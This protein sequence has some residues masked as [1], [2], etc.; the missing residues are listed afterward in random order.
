MDLIEL[1]DLEAARRFVTE[2]LWLQRAVKPNADT[3]L[4]V[5]GS[6][7]QVFS[8]LD[9]RLTLLMHSSATSNACVPLRPMP[10]ARTAS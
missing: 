4:A 7:T 2:G 10:C 1:R 8:P 6:P 3:G 9:Y 5:S